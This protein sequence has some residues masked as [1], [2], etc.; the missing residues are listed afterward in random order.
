MWKTSGQIAKLYGV[1]RMAVNKWIR[2]GR[3][4][5]VKTTLGGHYRIWY[6]PPQEI[7]GYVRVSS[8]KQQSSLDTQAAIIRREYPGIEIVSDVGS[9]FNFKRPGFRALLERC[10]SGTPLE[11]V[12]PTGDRLARTGLPFIVWAIE[13]HGGTVTELEESDCDEQF[14]TAELVGFI[15]SFIANY[16]GKRSAS[17]R[18]KKV[19]GVPRKR[20]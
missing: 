3:F 15:T 8:A 13:L 4:D 12:V 14:D 5:R 18:G 16:H 19:K 1:S 7:V 17:R 20:K 2:A 11:V 10:L 6:E 9:G